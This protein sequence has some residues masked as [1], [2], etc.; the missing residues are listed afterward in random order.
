MDPT[1]ALADLVSDI[2]LLPDPQEKL[3]A[4]T[5]WG[6]AAPTL[7][8][9]HRT[10]DLLVPGCVSRVHLRG[11]LVDGVMCYQLAADSAM[12]RGL[13]GVAVRL[14]NGATPASA[15]A[16]PYDWPALTRLD[17]HITP[18]RL[19][20]LAAVAARIRQLAASA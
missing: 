18:T 11:H 6:K 4:L 16:C 8:D 1:T 7:A 12:V 17:R 13:A 3:G 5:A 14:A 9:D 19:N 15:A 2:A 20:G 10:D